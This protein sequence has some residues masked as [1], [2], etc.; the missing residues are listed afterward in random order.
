MKKARFIGGTV[1]WDTFL[2]FRVCWIRGRYGGGKTTLGFIMSARLYAEGHARSVVSN[3]PLTI[4]SPAVAP[5]KDAAIL[6]DESWIYIET[7]KDVLDYAAFVRKFG[8]YLILPS[9]FPI[10]NR[11]S[12]FF[13]QRVFNGYTVGLPMWFYQ[14]GIRD[15]SVKESGYFAILNPT[16]VFNHFPTKFVAGDD[17]GI[18]EVLHVTAKMEG[19]KGT[20]KQQYRRRVTASDLAQVEISYNDDEAEE[21][22]ETLDDFSSSLDAGVSDMEEAVRKAS[23]FTRR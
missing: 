3:I 16:A 10:H 7:R 6:L 20:R 5:L 8:H 11:L 15:K 13:V 14:W 21:I 4:A 1:F 22:E 18:S 17:A 12:F 19:Y 9:V 2:A 23:R